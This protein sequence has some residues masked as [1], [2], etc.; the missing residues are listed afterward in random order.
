LRLKIDK[1]EPEGRDADC[2]ENNHEAPSFPK[3]DDPLDLTTE[4]S[5]PDRRK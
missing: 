1:V 5:G 4:L 3:N 2:D